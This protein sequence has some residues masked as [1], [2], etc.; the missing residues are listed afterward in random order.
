V[1]EADFLL[2][3]LSIRPVTNELVLADRLL[4]MARLLEVVPQ[5]VIVPPAI[6]LVCVYK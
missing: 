2:P 6:Q 3:S 4:I 5:K 1:L